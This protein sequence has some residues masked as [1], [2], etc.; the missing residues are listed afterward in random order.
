MACRLSQS[1]RVEVRVADP[2]KQCAGIS[3]SWL[4]EMEAG[5]YEGLLEFGKLEVWCEGC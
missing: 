3:P 4:E 2:D 1:Y 5:A